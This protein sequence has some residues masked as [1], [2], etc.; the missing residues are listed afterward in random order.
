MDVRRSQLIRYTHVHVVL[1]SGLH[2]S[3]FSL[4]ESPFKPQYD[5][6]SLMSTEP[7]NNIILRYW[8]HT[9]RHV[10]VPFLVNF[11]STIV[12]AYVNSFISH[13]LSMVFAR[14]FG[15]VGRQQQ[16]CYSEVYT[17][18]DPISARGGSLFRSQD[19]FT[20]GGGGGLNIHT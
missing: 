4:P 20:M 8:Q 14:N 6:V 7:S 3:Y 9:F 13:R 19:L 1:R 2:G 12:S 11:R 5:S 16:Y 15:P 18:C 10:F 17:F